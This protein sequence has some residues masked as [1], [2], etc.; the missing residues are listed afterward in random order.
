[1]ASWS[2][3]NLRTGRVDS[4]SRDRVYPVSSG[5]REKEFGEGSRRFQR[6]DAGLTSCGNAKHDAISRVSLPVAPTTL[7]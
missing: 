5:R 4:L 7:D 1:M 2:V 3:W 6:E